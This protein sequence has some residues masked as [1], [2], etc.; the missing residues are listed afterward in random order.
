MKQINKSK[1]KQVNAGQPSDMQRYL[2]LLPLIF[3]LMVVPFIIKL[4]EIS[5]PVHDLYWQNTDANATW[6]DCF[7]YT[8]GHYLTA[9]AVIMVFV[10]L[11]SVIHLYIKKTKGADNHEQIK[12]PVWFLL[13]AVMGILILLSALFS[14]NSSVSFHG[15]YEQFETPLVLLSY[16]VLVCYGFYMVRSEDDVALVFRFLMAGVTLMVVYGLFQLSGNDPLKW[17]FMQSLVIPS[18]REAEL[19]FNFGNHVVYMA[20]FNPNYVGTYVAVI[21]PCIFT[22]LS[23]YRKK[24]QGVEKN[25]TKYFAVVAGMMCLGIGLLLCL[26]GAGAKNG[27]FALAAVVL[28]LLFFYR[29]TIFKNVRIACISIA[30]CLVALAGVE[31]VSGAMLSGG[32]FEG[33]LVTNAVKSFVSGFAPS[34]RDFVLEDIQT[35]QENVTIRYKGEDLA[36]TYDLID[37]GQNTEILDL[38]FR[39]NSGNSLPYEVTEDTAEIIIQDSRFSSFSTIQCQLED[40]IGFAI[41]IDGFQWFFFNRP[42]NGG[43][44]YLNHQYNFVKIKNAESAI[45]TDYGK[46][47]SGRGYIWSRTLPLLKNSLFLGSGPDTFAME[48]P[49]DDYV[50]M[51]NNGYT[52]GLIT[53]PHSMYLQMGLQTGVLSLICFLVFYGIYFVSS[54]RLYCKKKPEQLIEHLGIGILAGTVGYMVAGLVNDSLVVTATFFWCLLGIGIA[55]NRILRNRTL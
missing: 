12:F 13:L 32:P 2:R 8:K 35:N 42:Q 17:P 43:Y 29:R 55:V 10:L 30:V 33:G 53:R 14:A 26:I 51:V 25:R 48:F 44:Y 40:E 41:T 23:G 50:G 19:T 15:I 31:T 22:Y 49:H 18:N 46:M 9:A 37:G 16:L 34:T 6:T 5:N 4:T 7:L 39:D 52:A 21:L 45:F 1:H 36:I 38:T 20:L 47:F 27:L 54:L 11:Y 24:N 3:V 28:I